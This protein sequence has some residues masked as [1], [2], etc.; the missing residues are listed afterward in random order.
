MTEL[1]DFIQKEDQT[2]ET[3][4]P[5]STQSDEQGQPLPETPAESDPEASED[6]EA[7]S[8]ESGDEVDRA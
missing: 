2:P 1:G 7:D 4:A 8:G 3:E 5:E 6:A